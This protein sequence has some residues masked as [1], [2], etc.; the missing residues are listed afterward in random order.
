MTSGR[1]RMVH[2]AVDALGWI[3]VVPFPNP[4]LSCQALGLNSWQITRDNRAPA[5]TENILN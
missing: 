4:I 5:I 2:L 3:P 1:P